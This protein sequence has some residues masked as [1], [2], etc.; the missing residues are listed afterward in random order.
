MVYFIEIYRGI[1]CPHNEDYCQLLSED[2]FPEIV[3]I[4]RGD[5]INI[6]LSVL[7]IAP[8]MM[9]AETVASQKAIPTFCPSSAFNKL[10]A[11]TV[12]RVRS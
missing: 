5:K 2:T 10:S 7:R 8:L 11:Y 1:F 3:T 6:L 12:A 4:K 9:N